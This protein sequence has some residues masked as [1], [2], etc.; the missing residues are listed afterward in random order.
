[1]DIIGVWERE[2]VR[3]E[4]EN[5]KKH[6]LKYKFDFKKLHKSNNFSEYQILKMQWKWNLDTS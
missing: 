2:D 4:T 6:W 1:M 3:N 5:L